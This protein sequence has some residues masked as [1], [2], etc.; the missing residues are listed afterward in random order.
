MKSKE[1]IAV[2]TEKAKHQR[3]VDAVCKWMGWVKVWREDVECWRWKVVGGEG[4]YTLL[5]EPVETY[6]PWRFREDLWHVM[7]TVHDVGLGKKF[8]D[9]W[10]RNGGDLM[11]F[12]IVIPGTIME[13]AWEVLKLKEK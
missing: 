2:E 8:I 9:E 6:D 3:R 11:L 13:I 1:Q 12:A 5:H 4:G 10:D 7:V